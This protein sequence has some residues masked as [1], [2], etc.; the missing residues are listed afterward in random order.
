MAKIELAKVDTLI[1][2]TH[3][4]VMS[5][6]ISVQG[7]EDGPRVSLDNSPSQ[8]QRLHHISKMKTVIVRY[9]KWGGE[10]IDTPW[11]DSAPYK[12]R[13]RKLK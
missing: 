10:Y 8:W 4:G 9:T 2:H 13:A 7:D 1:I 6:G 12:A 5:D 11:L 3:E